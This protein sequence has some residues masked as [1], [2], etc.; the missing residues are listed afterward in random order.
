MTKDVLNGATFEEAAIDHKFKSK[1]SASRAFKV[2]LVNFF[3][4]YELEEIKKKGNNI[5][6]IRRKWRE[7]AGS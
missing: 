1:Q 7:V 6:A 4:G 5:K 2:T 3:M